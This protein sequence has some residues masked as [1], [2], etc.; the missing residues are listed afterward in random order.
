MALNL[1]KQL[2]FVC[3]QCPPPNSPDQFTDNQISMV[4]TITIRY[5]EM[6]AASPQRKLTNRPILGQRGNTH[7]M[8]APATDNWHLIRTKFFAPSQ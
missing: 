4:H 7:H 6:L 2:L 1:E 8:R 5:E 3:I